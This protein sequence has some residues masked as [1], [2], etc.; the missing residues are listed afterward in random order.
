MVLLPFVFP[1]AKQSDCKKRSIENRTRQVHDDLR[2]FFGNGARPFAVFHFEQTLPRALHDFFIGRVEEA[3]PHFPKINA[4]VHFVDESN[5]IRGELFGSGRNL[6]LFLLF[7]AF[8]FVARRG[9]VPMGL[10]A[11]GT[12]G[13]GHLSERLAVRAGRRRRRGQCSGYSARAVRRSTVPFERF[14]AVAVHSRASVH[15]SARYR[16]WSGFRGRV[17]L[18]AR[19]RAVRPANW[20]AV[21]TLLFTGLHQAFRRTSGRYC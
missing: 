8:A 2:W 19:R 7:V 14:R 17:T 15:S 3:P 13:T 9:P 20:M 21:R 4:C 1:P 5:P 16:S 11:P 12:R 6:L 18:P 10:F